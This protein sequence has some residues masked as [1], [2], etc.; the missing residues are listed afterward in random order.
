MGR[1]LIGRAGTVKLR[2]IRRLGE[3]KLFPQPAVLGKRA[4]P[5]QLTPPTRSEG[6]ATGLGA[7]D[8]KLVGGPEDLL[9]APVAA[10]GENTTGKLLTVGW[11]AR[12][13][14]T[15]EAERPGCGTRGADG[16]AEPPGF[17][18]GGHGRYRPS[19]SISGFCPSRRF[20]CSQPT[21]SVFW[22]VSSVSRGSEG[23]PSGGLRSPLCIG[24]FFVCPGNRKAWEVLYRLLEEPLRS[25]R[26]STSSLGVKH[27]GSPPLSRKDHPAGK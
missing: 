13:G 18:C 11:A 7:V 6:S 22:S 25:Q 1:E 8:E 20:S 16:A 5:A 26:G 4:M 21:R 12:R 10:V 9:V 23:C 24:G 19:S 15:L 2:P 14:L 17:G 27:R 3:K